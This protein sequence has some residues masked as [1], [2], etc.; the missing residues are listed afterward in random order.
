ML[1]R[2]RRVRHHRV[3]EG[4]LGAVHARSAGEVTEVNTALGE[5]PETVNADPHDSWMIAIKLADGADQAEL[6]DA[7]QYTE[8]TR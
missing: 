2:G 1:E 4:G 8:L 3:G 6:L 5:K 7:G